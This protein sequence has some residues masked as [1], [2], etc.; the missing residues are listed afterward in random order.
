[1][2]AVAALLWWHDPL[3]PVVTAS[4]LFAITTWLWTIGAVLQSRLGLV[5]GGV[6]MLVALA[7]LP[8]VGALSGV[9]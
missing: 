3:P 2:G 8:V 5:A 7:S 6:V 1:M 4:A 9:V